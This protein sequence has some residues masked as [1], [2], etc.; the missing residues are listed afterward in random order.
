M[1][2]TKLVKLKYTALFVLFYEQ[3]LQKTTAEESFDSPIESRN[4][5]PSASMETLTNINQSDVDNNAIESCTEQLMKL[6]DEFEVST[7][8]SHYCNYGNQKQ[9]FRG[10]QGGKIAPHCVT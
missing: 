6:G 8:V 2:S 5:D 1:Q 7:M 9:L 10:M 4:F 3:E